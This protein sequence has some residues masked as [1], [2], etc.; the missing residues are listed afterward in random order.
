MTRNVQQDTLQTLEIL[1]TNIAAIPLTSCSNAP[2]QM[3]PL[4][5]HPAGTK[6]PMKIEPW[7]GGRCSVTCL[8]NNAA[9][10]W[11]NVQP[12]NRRRLLEIIGPLFMSYGAGNRVCSRL[13][14]RVVG[15]TRLRFAPSRYYSDQFPPEQP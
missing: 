5:H 10:F 4:N 15:I 2:R 1:E 13:S 7:P 6:M 9:A 14:G 3:G 11:D 8:V 12:S